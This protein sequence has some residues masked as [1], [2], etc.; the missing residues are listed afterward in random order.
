MRIEKKI[1]FVL[2]IV[3]LTINACK[4]E[5]EDIGLPPS[6]VEAI[7]SKW[8]LSTF[9]VT[10]KS[11]IVDET[12]DMTEYYSGISAMPNITL[13]ILGTDTTFTSDTAGVKLNL[14]VAPSGRWRFD[15]MDFPSKVILM[16]DAKIQIAEF[17]LLAP[18]KSYDNVLKI[19][20][21]TYCGTKVVYTYDL[22][23][24]RVSN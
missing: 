21:A 15:N 4:K 13:T 6:K 2:A 19:S 8:V 1:L 10:D 20:Q 11:G 16:N 5:Y 17:N 12:M 23:L 14:F 9:N 24:N 3:S 18:I 22:L 7:T